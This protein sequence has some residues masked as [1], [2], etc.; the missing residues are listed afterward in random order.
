M[1][2]LVLVFIKKCYKYCN[3]EKKKV[4]IF[5]F[6]KEEYNNECFIKYLVQLERKGKYN[7]GIVDFILEFIEG[8]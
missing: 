7:E 4:V 5:E 3:E 2:F 6:I 1:S 8:F